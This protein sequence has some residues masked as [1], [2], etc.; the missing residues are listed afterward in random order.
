MRIFAHR[1]NS[2]VY[3]ENTMAAFRSALSVGAEG[4]ETDVHLTKDGILVITHDEEISRVSDGKGQVK[5]MTLEE[6]QR[7]DFGSWKGDAYKGEKIPTLKELLDLLKDTD[8]M[9]NIE[10]KMGFVLYPGIEEKL[11][12]LIKAE[13]FLS[14]VIFSS[15]NHYS[16]A[17]IKQLEPE[18]KTAPL[19]ECGLFQP[20]EY[21][22]TLGAS[23]IH[24]SYRSMDPRLLEDLKKNSIG[25]NLWT[26]NDI[27]TAQYFNTLGIDGIITDHPE[28]LIQALRR[29]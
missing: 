5:D 18:A 25:V 3:P 12:E 20:H 21:A 24:S 6:L 15:F 23:F 26:V 11:L 8:L 28:E 14:R 7:Y 27:Q 1:G 4:I 2:S 19:Y 13:G 9:L 10:I 29:P 16:I 17:L 22:K